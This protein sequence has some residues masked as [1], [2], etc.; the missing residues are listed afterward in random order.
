MQL[1]DKY[2]E[3]DPH[4][5]TRHH[6]DSYNTFV[7]KSI[8]TAIKSFNPFPIIKYDPSGKYIKHKFEIFIGGVN[9]TNLRFTA[10]TPTPINARL[11]NETY[12]SDLLVNVIIRTTYTKNN[13]DFVEERELK[14][15]L[16][17]KMPV[18]LHS[19]L[20]ILNTKNEN[21]T[22]GECPYDQGG[23]FIVDGKEKV[24]IGQES[25]VTNRLFVTSVDNDDHTHQ[26]FIRCVAE[27]NSVFPKTIWF[28]VL[29]KKAKS[30][31]REN[32]IVIKMPH[33]NKQIPLFMLFR[34]LG[35][36]ND[37]SILENYIKA[38]DE[39]KEFLRP[40][41][42]DC[43]LYSQHKC[44]EYLSKY[45]DFDSVTHVRY[46]ILN[47]LFPNTVTTFEDKA[48]FLG[49]MIRQ[50]VNTC[51]K[52]SPESNRDNFMYKRV[53]VS[54]FLLADIFKDFYNNF[55]VATR[56]KI[57]NMYEFG[58]GTELENIADF[59]NI[60]NA[61]EIFSQSEKMLYGL[62]KSLKGNWGLTGDS[63]KQ[64]IVQDLNR[65]SYMSFISHLRRVNLP[66]DT[67]VKIR[68]PHQLNGSQWGVMCPCESPD[69]ASIGLI[70]NMSILCKIS[71]AVDTDIIKEALSI[72]KFTKVPM[73]HECVRVEINKIFYGY[74]HT[75]YQANDFVHYIRLLRRNGYIN[76][77]T[78]IVWT[79]FEKT[80]NISCDSGRCLR[81]LIHNPKKSKQHSGSWIS[82]LV[83]VV[84]QKPTDTYIDPLKIL[85]IS[86]NDISFLKKTISLL[87]ENSGFIEYIDVEEANSCLISFDLN[88]KKATHWEI[89]P[90][91]VFSAYTSTIPL[92]NHNQAP[93]NIFS[94]AQGKQAIGVY[95]TNFPYRI[96]TMSYVL[97]YPQMPLVGTKYHKYLKADLLPNGENVIVAICTYTGYNQED[98]IIINKSSIERG[99]F[100][101][102]YYTSHIGEEDTMKN[103]SKI[104]FANP[105][106]IDGCDITK[107]ANYKKL[108]K[109][110]MPIMNEFI[111]EG[112]ALLGK[113]LSEQ[114][115]EQL[116]ENTIFKYKSSSIKYISKC[117]IADKTVS[118]FVDKVVL[119]KGKGDGDVAKI[120]LRKVRIPE[121]GDKLASRHGQK[122]VIGAILP[123]EMM[124]FTKDGIVPDIIINPHALPSRMTIGHLIESILA[125]IG[126]Y[127]S[128]RFDATPFN[129]QNFEDVYDVLEKKYNMNRY[130]DELIYNGITGEQIE[131]KI[132]IGPTYYYRLKHMVADKINYRRDGKI[133]SMTKQ[134]TKGRG[135]QGG[136]RIGE[137][138]TNAIISHGVSA[139]MKESMME[140]SDKYTLSDENIRVPYAYKLLKQELESMS[141]K[142]D[143]KLDIEQK[144]YSIDANEDFDT[145]SNGDEELDDEDENYR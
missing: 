4:F 47:N 11:Y 82:A 53:G 44:L 51:L 142:V 38:D 26:A 79:I 40:S 96:D 75:D 103:G 71:E 105:N 138:E 104:F 6:L 116:E 100:N 113:V 97:H 28:Y 91:T 136:L 140:R 43:N 18:M 88:N 60:N 17:C 8:Q 27:K 39:M 34:A 92:A 73:N 119:F 137:M 20:C 131:T 85:K 10:A 15:I 95:A 2:F 68:A 111:E 37:K 94:G 21:T 3:S 56:T 58:G 77:Y 74:L 1:L 25:T 139:F 49:E 50:I 41:I 141:I 101:L 62:T 16:L 5:L 123:Q 33:I 70:K 102:T 30:A 57:D 22:L 59:I 126:T 72:F 80:V 81:P 83:G 87:E 121:L 66:M 52:R 114:K 36:E 31:L 12:S 115:E 93:R 14:D 23:Y 45:V 46:A 124:P 67:S 42:I 19:D 108:D 48:I 132:F 64:G 134:P 127:T 144:L 120:R 99:L 63:T 61:K 55:R 118:G 128:T 106:N 89:H 107:F 125:K 129:N 84:N 130:G 9:G 76:I 109:N 65:L 90:T 35:I 133:V 13:K 7:N 98:S 122:G 69:G 110:G 135:N 32:A 54:G 78:A 29:K 117:D 24:I 112:D 86:D 145:I 143:H